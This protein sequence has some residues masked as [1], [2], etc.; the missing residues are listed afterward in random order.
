M[1]RSDDAGAPAP[2]LLG[3]IGGMDEACDRQ[4]HGTSCLASLHGRSERKQN[5]SLRPQVPP[6]HPVRLGKVGDMSHVDGHVQI[7]LV[8]S[9]SIPFLIGVG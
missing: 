9:P 3:H 5:E 1:L 6:M 4:G 2:W 7:L 8:N